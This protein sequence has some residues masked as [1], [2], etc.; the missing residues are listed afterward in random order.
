MIEYAVILL[1]LTSNIVFIILFIRKDGAHR[2]LLKQKLQK[3]SSSSSLLLDEIKY[4]Q[5]KEDKNG[6]KMLTEWQRQREEEKVFLDKHLTIASLA[7]KMGTNKTVLSKVINK[8]TGHTFPS[9]LNYYRIQEAVNMLKEEQNK[10]YTLEY[11]GEKCGYANRQVFHASFK[12][13]VGMTPNRFK[14]F[15][16]NT[17]MQSKISN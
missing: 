9:L 12:Q 11:I 8:S 7:A 6:Q 3:Q 10:Q 2:N 15:V 13:E 17:Q 16:I 5:D 14:K 1:L 4:E